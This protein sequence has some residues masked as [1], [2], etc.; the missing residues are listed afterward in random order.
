MIQKDDDFP[1]GLLTLKCLLGR[2]VCSLE[3]RS[4]MDINIWKSSA[5]TV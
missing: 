2:Q 4:E 3:E 5:N 1:F